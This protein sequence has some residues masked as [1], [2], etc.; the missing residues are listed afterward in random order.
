MLLLFPSA[1]ANERVAG[2]IPML[3]TF[4][5][6]P[7]ATYIFEVRNKKT[8]HVSPQNVLLPVF[9]PAYFF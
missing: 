4:H 1:E 9:I 5:V 3:S 6:S 2:V 7:T 8:I